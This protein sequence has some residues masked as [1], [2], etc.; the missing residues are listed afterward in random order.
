MIVLSCD[1][2][3]I[4]SGTKNALKMHLSS[5][6]KRIN[7]IPITIFWR[8]NT[9]K[10]KFCIYLTLKRYRIV[11]LK[12]FKIEKNYNNDFNQFF[13]DFNQFFNDFNQFFNDSNQFYEISIRWSLGL[14]CSS[15]SLNMWWNWSLK[16]DPVCI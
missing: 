5:N 9:A 4:L 12:S 15:H 1:V 2:T 14:S 3:Q 7:Q 13:N 16:Y 10:D 11:P 6:T 8:T